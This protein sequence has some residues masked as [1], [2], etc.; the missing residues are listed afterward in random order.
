MNPMDQSIVSF[1][2]QFA[3]L[4]WT[5]DRF[6][7][8]FSGCTLLKGGIVM[9]LLWW[10]WFRSDSDTIGRRKKVIS[11]FFASVGA[12]TVGRVL[13][14]L[15]P[16]RL[17]PLNNESLGFLAPYGVRTGLL[18]ELSSFPSDHAILFAALS[19]GLFLISKRVGVATFLYSGI[20]VLL[21]RIYLGL[22]YPSDILVGILVGVVIAWA[23]VSLIQRS[24][25]PEIFVAWAEKRPGIY[26]PAFFLIS[27]QI[28]DLFDDSRG[29]LKETL[30]VVKALLT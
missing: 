22:H 25:I 15:L 16:F 7:F 21:P 8:F 11:V 24:A 1:L 18:E 27:Y 5:L 20:F 19:T 17:R 2:N 3:Q 26:Y 23:G 14:T 28:A 10:M 9:T 12:L 29:I 4:S 30:T 13:A 6:I